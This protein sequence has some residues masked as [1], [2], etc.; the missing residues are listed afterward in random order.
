MGQDIV[1]RE[2]PGLNIPKSSN[3]CEI[4]IVDTTT[5][6]TCPANTLLEPSIK[7]HELLNCPTVAF[8]I[9]HN[10]KQIMFDL[11]SKEDWWNVSPADIILRRG[12]SL[13]RP[14]S[15]PCGQRDQE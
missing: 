7:G 2:A 13:T 8:L 12:E 10:G 15:S 11:G 3:T 14:V 4:S 6:I 9:R 5:K 1:A